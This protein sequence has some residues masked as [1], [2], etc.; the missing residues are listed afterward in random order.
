MRNVGLCV[1]RVRAD[2]GEVLKTMR[3]AALK[4]APSAFGSTY[5]AEA[6]GTDAD[7][8]SRARAGAD[9][10]N[11]VTFFALLDDRIVGL[12]GGFRPDHDRSVVDLVSMWTTPAARR[13]G[14]GRA[15]VRSVL[16]WAHETD[17]AAVELWVTRENDAAR[18]LYE[19]LGFAETGDVRPLPSDSCRDELRMRFRL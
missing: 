3:L 7:W 13:T 9:G 19:S 12:V 14:A 1:R 8:T 10:S 18:R 16:R 15:L 11:Q 4:D 17:A 2:D 5:D 6:A